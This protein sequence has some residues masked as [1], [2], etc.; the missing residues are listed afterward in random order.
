MDNPIVSIIVPVYNMEKYLDR[1]I[2]SLIN[3]T[4]KDIEIILVDD[5]SFDSSPQ[6]CNQWAKKDQRIKVVLKENRGVSSA[7]NYGIEMSKGTYL[8]FVDADDYIDSNY[9]FTLFQKINDGYDLVCSSYMDISKYGV[10]KCNDFFVQEYTKENLINCIINGTG[11]VLWN[12]IF[13]RDIII[14]NDIRMSEKLF[15]SEDLIFILNYIYYIDKW[16]AIDRPLYH[17]N[18]LNQNSISQSV[19]LFYLENYQIFFEEIDKCF[20][21]LKVDTNFSEQYK[22]NRIS[23]LLL[24]FIE[25]SNDRKKTIK[26]LKS[27][28]FFN[29]YFDKCQDKDIVLMLSFNKHYFL[30]N[31]YILIKNII[32]TSGKFIKKLVIK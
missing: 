4:L 9:I 18:R 26:I 10:V 24:K 19:N 23:F 7:R 12:K 25:K 32:K 16:S 14:K 28:Y 20:N 31:S 8:C 21:R 6:I 11:G 3:Q 17:Y 1:C 27:N 15:M 22:I 2:K 13:L 30:L 29:S 5:G